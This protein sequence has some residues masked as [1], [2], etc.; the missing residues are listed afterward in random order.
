MGGVVFVV[1]DTSP[2]DEDSSQETHCNENKAEDY[3]Q[4]Y[5]CG[6]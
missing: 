1:F 2:Q 3:C 6:G 5:D 4:D